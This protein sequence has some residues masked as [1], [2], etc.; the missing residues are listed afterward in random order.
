MRVLLGENTK[1]K[2]TAVIK[3]YPEMKVDMNLLAKEG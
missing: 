1:D 2:E 3:N